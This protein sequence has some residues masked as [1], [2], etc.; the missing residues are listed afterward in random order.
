MQHTT[1][2]RNTLQ[3]MCTATQCVPMRYFWMR[4]FWMGIC[5][6][7]A[8]ILEGIAAT[9]CNALQHTTTRCNTLQHAATHC[10]TLFTRAILLD[11]Y[12]RPNGAHFRRYHCNTLQHTTKHCN[13]LQHTEAH[14]ST[15]QHTA[16]HCNTQR[17]RNLFDHP[18]TLSLV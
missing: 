17:A 16:T 2:Y 9:H 13:T 12:L 8:R 6:P 1:T 11:R 3:H 7:K 14:C 5:A 18:T 15:Q 10:R 4:S